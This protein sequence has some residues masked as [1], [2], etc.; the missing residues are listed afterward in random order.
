MKALDSQDAFL[1]R[2]LQ[3]AREQSEK[4]I[5]EGGP[6]DPSVSFLKRFTNPVGN[7]LA[8]L[9]IRDALDLP[10]TYQITTT[11]VR[12]AVL[13]ALL[14]PLRQSVGSCF[15]TAPA[16]MIQNE[17]RERLLQDLFDLIY[18]GKLKRVIG[19]KEYI[20]PLCHTSGLGNLMKKVRGDYLTGI[21][22]LPHVDEPHRFLTISA[23]IRET[24]FKK[25]QI[26]EKDLLVKKE[27][28]FVV[29]PPLNVKLFF[30]EEAK[31]RREYCRLTEHALLKAWEYSIASFAD[32][33][34]EFFRWNLYASLGFNHKDPGGIGE[35]IYQHLQE[36]LDHSNQE[37]KN[38]HAEYEMSYNKL[39][40]VEVLLAR[41][42]GY[43]EARRLKAE[44]QASLHHFHSLKEMRDES[45]YY[46]ER[47]SRLYQ[48]LMEA[49]ASHLQEHFQEIFDPEVVDSSPS[50]YDDQPA[51][52]RLV[53]KHGRSDSSQWTLI[54]DEETFVHALTNFFRMTENQIIDQCD[55]KKGKKEIE[56]VTTLVINY[57]RG[58]AF[59][60]ATLE[61]LLRLHGHERSPWFYLSGGS[62]H[63]LVKCYYAEENEIREESRVVDSPKDLFIFLLD[64]MKELPARVV[65]PFLDNPYKSLLMYSPSH[66]FLLR[67]GLY[68]FKQGWLDKGLSYIWI[69]D[70]IVDPA[71]RF[72][73]QIELDFQKQKDLLYYLGL[74][75][76]EPSSRTLT[77]MDFRTLLSS[78]MSTASIDSF[79]RSAFPLMP[80]EAFRGF[81]SPPTDFVPY[82]VYRDVTRDPKLEVPVAP[83]FADTNWTGYFFGFVVNPATLDLEL[84]RMDEEGFEGAP[85]DMWHSFFGKGEWGVLTDPRQYQ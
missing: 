82:K 71:Q 76:V 80:K 17:Q 5:P 19:G 9:Y 36:R 77:L 34:V 35:L 52:F 25:Y 81:P 60:P 69:R 20:V 11:Y 4:L 26:G 42:T 47:F 66:A 73:S 54:Q 43:D 23:W 67:P 63:S 6:L 8:E 3:K 57:L 46:A 58:D 75:K 45:E 10:D 84:W 55:W 41:A 27:G 48:F 59:M 49:Y 29:P 65:E 30:E 37:T 24:L 78:Y 56:E 33:K 64:I 79:F 32:Y 18:K 72:Y 68:P 14:M 39:R 31:I 61:R 70:S 1:F 53:Y 21:E 50:P 28:L 2:H 40:S 13:S 16:I 38:I 7:H 85:M 15:A 12:R 83:L 51:G 74:N 22:L 44:L 62:M